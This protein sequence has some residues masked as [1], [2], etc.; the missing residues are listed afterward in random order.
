MVTEESR[1]EYNHIL[2]SRNFK[3]RLSTCVLS[4]KLVSAIQ[5]SG[6]FPFNDD[7][8]NDD[9]FMTATVT[10]M[11]NVVREEKKPNDLNASEIPEID[12]QS[13][14]TSHCQDKIIETNQKHS[15]KYIH[16]R[17]TKTV[18]Q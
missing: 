4:Q 6:V 9:D 5:A 13:P 8:F 11:P 1:K 10:D 18:E 14:P 2:Y 12:V 7:I 15:M 17:K 16:L 3:R